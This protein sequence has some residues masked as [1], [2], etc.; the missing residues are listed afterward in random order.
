MEATVIDIIGNVNWE[1]FLHAQDICRFRYSADGRSGTGKESLH[2]FQSFR[3]ILG[4]ME[5]CRLLAITMKYFWSHPAAGIAVN[6]STIHV[7][8]TTYILRSPLL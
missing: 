7:D 3:L 5:N 8:I 4:L 6:T 1:T 2:C